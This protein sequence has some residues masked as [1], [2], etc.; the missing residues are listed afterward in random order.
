M[1]DEA[2]EYPLEL[3]GAHRR[4]PE[5]DAAAGAVA[6]EQSGRGGAG[7]MSEAR[8]RGGESSDGG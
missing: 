2:L 1:L 7:D 6:E 3:S 4:N 8:G 5:E